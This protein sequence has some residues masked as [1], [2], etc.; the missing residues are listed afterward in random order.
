MLR[1][2]AL[3]VEKSSLVFHSGMICV[4]KKVKEIGIL[5]LDIFYL[6]LGIE[7]CIEIEFSSRGLE[8]V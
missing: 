4:S 6:L 5:L 1:L 8:V 3:K 2:V 7:G